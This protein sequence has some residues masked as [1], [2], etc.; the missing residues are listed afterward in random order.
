MKK[1]L[2]GL[3]SAAALFPAPALSQKL[4]ALHTVSTWLYESW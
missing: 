2:L 3:L 4:G 1:L